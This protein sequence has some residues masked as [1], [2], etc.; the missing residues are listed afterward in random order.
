MQLQSFSHRRIVLLASLALLGMMI[1]QANWVWTSYE[2][3]R[4]EVHYEL[5]KLTPKVAVQVK[6]AEDIIPKLMIREGNLPNVS[7]MEEIVD[8]MVQAAGFTESVYFTLFQKSKDSLYISNTHDYEE[9]LRAS[10]YSTCLSCIVTYRFERD[11][12]SPITPEMTSIRPVSEMKRLPGYLPSEEFVWFNLYMPNQKLLSQRAILGLFILSVLMM[13]I[14]IYLFAH[15]LNALSLQKKL[16]QMKDDFVNNLTHEF[17]TPL[18]AIRLASSVLKKSDSEE[19]RSIYLDLIAN[20]SKKL[21]EQVDRMLQLSTLDAKR[22]GLDKE[23]LD[24]HE[25][26]KEVTHR[27]LPLALQRNGNIDLQLNLSDSIVS[28]DRDHLGNCIYNLVDNAIKYA[29]PAPKVEVITREQG[30]IRQLIVRDHGPGISTA[31]HEA[32]FDR[33][34]RAQEEDRYKGK[35]FGI[36]LSYVK[37]I[38]EAHQGRVS[39]NRQYRDGCEFIIELR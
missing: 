34:Y 32:I 20:E 28:A 24:L 3:K 1:V 16:G 33:F 12:A 13:G 17:K 19:K 25:L 37:T 14:L 4:E 35:G 11:S 29:G 7:L 15:I 31:H 38:V 8:S 23:E 39:L 27:L 2:L 22:D 30:A 18:G 10:P 9:E 5:T 21:E 36:G 26:I 6:I